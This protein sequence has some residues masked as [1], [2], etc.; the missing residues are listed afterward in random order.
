MAAYD[1]LFQSL[2]INGL[3]VKNR[4]LST[5][6]SPAYAENGV[7]TDRYIAYQAEKA[8]G[9]VGLCQFGGATTVG[10][11]CS[12]YYGQ[13]NGHSDEVIPRYK[14]MAAAIHEHG[15][16]CTVQ[17]THGGRRERWDI[18]NWLP[19]FASGFD[20]SRLTPNINRMAEAT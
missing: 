20:Q 4:F 16:A 3:T 15:A 17:L 9:G 13:I 10:P 6:H 19:A 14:A 12:I 8:R 11:E 5:S 18:A 1:A 7:I 2:K